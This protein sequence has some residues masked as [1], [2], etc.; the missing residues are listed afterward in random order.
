MV[1]YYSLESL[2]RRDAERFFE[3][4]TTLKDVKNLDLFLLSPGGLTDPAFKIAR[5]CQELVGEGRFSV[6]IPLYAKSAATI[7]ALGADELIMGPPSELGPIDPQ[8]RMNAKK[9]PV[10]LHALSDALQQLEQRVT[11]NLNL[12]LFYQPLIDSLDLMSLGHYDREI[13]GA[14]QYAEYLLSQR[15]FKDD[16]AKAKPVSQ[17]LTAEYKRHSYVIDRQEAHQ[18]L[19]LNVK[20]ASPAEWEAMW[21]LHHLYHHLMRDSISQGQPAKV[22]ETANIMLRG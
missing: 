16:P 1:V 3:V 20:D 4:L 22:I 21:Q 9:P 8:L 18:T 12:S 17:R 5:L 19:Q 13:Q 6:L 15:M 14:Q 2:Q 10:P 11:S 7:L